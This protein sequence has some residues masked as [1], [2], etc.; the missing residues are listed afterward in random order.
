MSC[1]NKKNTPIL[2]TKNVHLKR[3]HYSDYFARESFWI[4]YLD[5]KLKILPRA[6]I[7]AVCCISHEDD[8]RS[9][10]LPPVDTNEV[11]SNN[12]NSFPAIAFMVNFKLWLSLIHAH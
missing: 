12:D 11:V 8:R 4:R 6:N 2:I 5:T 9:V 10:R 7:S 1:I 3:F